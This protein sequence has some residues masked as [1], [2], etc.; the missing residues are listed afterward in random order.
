MKIARKNRTSSSDFFRIRGIHIFALIFTAIFVLHAPLLRLPYFW[1]EAG[2]YIPTAYDF[3]TQG[4]LIPTSVPSNAH[5]PFLPAYL[6]FWWKLSAFKPAVTRTAML[7]VAALGLAAVF[8]LSQ[9]IT[10][11]RVATAVTA[12]TPH[13]IRRLTFRFRNYSNG[14]ISSTRKR[15]TTPIGRRQPVTVR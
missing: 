1:D 14:R 11:A 7:L 2:Y 6:A 4:S 13:S 15:V 8:K 5:P 12:C 3:F 9:M 10:N